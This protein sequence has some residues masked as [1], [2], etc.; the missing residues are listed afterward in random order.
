MIKFAIRNKQGLWRS[1]GSSQMFGSWSEAQLWNNA[2][3]AK[4]EI[5]T[6]AKNLKWSFPTG[7]PHEGVSEPDP[8]ICELVTIY[9][10]EPK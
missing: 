9:I 3:T 10:P 8:I 2:K 7:L 6:Q 5:D 4:K 1:A